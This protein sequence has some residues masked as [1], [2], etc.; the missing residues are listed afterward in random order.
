MMKWSEA[1]PDGV[2][3]LHLKGAG[4]EQVLK[5]ACSIEK[6]SFPKH[7]SMKES[8]DREVRKPRA[9]LLYILDPREGGKDMAGFALFTWEGSVGQIAK[10][11]VRD[12]SRRMG[13]GEKLLQVPISIFFR[14]RFRNG[15]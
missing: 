11:V 15:P 12:R 3:I 6:K 5:E 4:S 14:I 9:C 7:M 10:L 2:Q 8:L 1:L 13:F